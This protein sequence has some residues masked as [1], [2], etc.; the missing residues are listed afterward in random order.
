MFLTDGYKLDH[1]RQYPKGTEFVYSNLTARSSKHFKLPDGKT[2]DG[3]VVFGIKYLCEKYL[4]EEFNKNL[5]SRK[6]E[7][8]ADEYYSFIKNYLGKDAADGIG[9]EHVKE[10]HRLGYLPVEILA[11]PEGVICPIGVPCMTIINTHPKFYWVTNFLE[12]LISCVLWMP[13]TSATMAREFKKELKRHCNLTGIGM[14]DFLVHDFSMRGMPGVD[15]AVLSGMGHLTSFYGSE[16]LP[17]VIELKKYYNESEDVITAGTVAATEHSVACANTDYD[18]EGNASDE[19]YIDHMLDVYPSGF[20]SIVA[21]TYDFWRFLTEYISQRKDRIMARDGRVVVRPDSGIP[22]D[23]IAGDPN[24]EPS[25]PEYK[26]A[27]E[28]L[29]DIFG[30][31]ISDNGYKI[32]DTHVGIIYGDSITIERQAEI[33]RRLERKGFSA[34]NLVLGI[35]SY[36]Y[37]GHATRDS[38]GFAVK[39]TWA[40]INGEPKELFKDPKTVVGMPKKSLRGFIKVDFEDD[41]R[42]IAIDRQN[43]MN[44]G[45]LKVVFRNGKYVDT[46]DNSLKNIRERISRSL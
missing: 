1:R 43:S 19:A 20:F 10:L 42:I 36:T 6:E 34:S 30:G 32:L 41:G 33:Y 4:I 12:T 44:S 18:N 21:D 15:G 8:V 27:Y 16:S 39:A 24:A 3:H 38:L 23:I 37:Q 7:D 13:M 31:T 29:W 46:A 26:G 9:V 28:I 40:Q 11:L 2:L 45:L 35:G 5:F 25:T 22:E 14:N 17:A